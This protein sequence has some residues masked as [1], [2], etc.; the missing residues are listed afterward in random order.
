MCGIA[1]FL[2]LEKPLFSPT[3]TLTEMSQTMR[4]RGPDA[5][6]SWLNQD[7]TVGMAHRRL[8]I[9]DLDETSNQPMH[10]KELGLSI[11]F[12]GEIYNYRELRKDLQEQ[13]HVFRS[14][15]D[16][17]V[18]LHL[19]QRYGVDMLSRLRGMY[20]FVLWDAT[21]ETLVMTRDPL[22]IKPLYH[23]TVNGVL[24]FASQVKS[25]RPLLSK[26][27]E[28]PAGRAAFLLWG[29]V[30]EPYTFF[31]DIRAVPAGAVMTARPGGRLEVHQGET[32]G[33]L[34]A[35][36]CLQPIA[37]DPRE[38]RELLRA[39]LVDSLSAHMTADVPVALFLSAGLDSATIAALLSETQACPP[40]TLTLGFHGGDVQDETGLA[41]EIA[42]WYNLDN[43]SQHYGQE[44][45]AEMYQD[46]LSAMD[47]PSIDGINVYLVSRMAKHFGFKVAMSG[48]GGDE[49]FG[50]YPSFR[51]IP[52]MKRN[53][54]WAGAIPGL[55]K[56]V[57]VLAA[58]ATSRLTSP[59]YAGMLEYSSTTPG[60]YLLRR[61]LYMPWEL[62]TVMDPELAR[63]G[64]RQLAE[65]ELSGLQIPRGLLPETADRVGVHI[66][67]MTMY[68][69]HQ[70]LR[71]ADWA[72]MANS[73]E[74]RVPLADW[75]L[76]TTLAPYIARGAFSKQDM[77]ATPHRPLPRHILDRPKTGFAA[78]VREWVQESVAN[79]EPQR[80]LRAWARHLQ[81][82]F[83][84]GVYLPS[85]TISRKH[86]T[87]LAAT[88]LT[89][90]RN[91]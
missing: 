1:G 47:Q 56:A 80:G 13:G 73:V 91:P 9:I 31:R 32:V 21:K 26:E 14:N 88:S 5:N 87:H 22:G 6:G 19:Y 25:L 41:A 79:S 38:R 29:S 44:D 55:G 2:A 34:L 8:S 89:P 57:R 3:A 53:F 90:Q 84:T 65:T 28:D 58:P 71:D 78:P 49:L 64:L 77:A 23:C 83:S 68:M 30:P 7:A 39:A 50:G 59:K 52:K 62:K 36:A 43:R 81:T 86:A 66:L 74:V 54:G 33:G 69:R 48:L 85:P 46:I 15:G 24:Y 51:Q 60:A 11:I 18:L 12:N 10:L 40:Q 4:D 27:I 67:E 75:K 35:K 37:T 72:G 45:F 17:E 70:L 16:T 20:A 76:L 63:E 61:G 82:I 42:R